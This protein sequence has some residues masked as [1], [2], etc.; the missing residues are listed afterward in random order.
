MNQEAYEA[1]KLRIRAAFDR[2]RE[3]LGLDE[4]EVTLSYHDAE[5]VRRDGAGGSAEAFG[6]TTVD[7][8]YRRATL[9][10]RVDMAAEES[11]DDVEYVVVHEAMHVLLNGQRAMRAASE[12]GA[13]YLNYERLFEEHTATTLARAFI[14][15][16]KLVVLA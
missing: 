11:D 14:R 4:W 15:A 1:Q 7:W 16:R 5:Y 12:G 6:M 2:W 8:E 10:F 9:D 13:A 3:V